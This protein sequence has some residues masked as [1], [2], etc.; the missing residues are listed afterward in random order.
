M[1]YQPSAGAW[2]TPRSVVRLFVVSAL[3]GV[4]GLA[5]QKHS[6]WHQRTH[7]VN[8]AGLGDIATVRQCLD[9]GVNVNTIGWQGTKAIQWASYNGHEEVVRL[10]LSRGARP[11]DGLKQAEMMHH[12][13]I[14]RLLLAH[15]A[16]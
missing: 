6:R 11:Q 10:L 4:C 13:S 7:F 2:A 15:G 12:E 1:N 14:V 8:A 16:R 5:V 9:D 3:L